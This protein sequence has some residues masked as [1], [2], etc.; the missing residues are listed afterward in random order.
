MAHCKLLKLCYWIQ[1]WGEMHLVGPHRQG[2]GSACSSRCLLD[3]FS[4]PLST[5]GCRR[6]AILS[7]FSNIVPQPPPSAIYPLYPCLSLPLTSQGKHWGDLSIFHQIPACALTVFHL[8][9]HPYSL[10]SILWGRVGPSL[11]LNL[12]FRSPSPQF[13]LLS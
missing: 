3:E 11:K 9:I 6:S 12:V 1:I 7:P 10:S 5:R 8:C 4:N 13:P 2:Q